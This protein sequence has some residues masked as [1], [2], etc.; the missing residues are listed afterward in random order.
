MKCILCAV[1]N[2]DE[3]VERLV[4]YKEAGFIVSLNLHPYSPGHLIIFP[5]RH[6]LDIREI[7]DEEGLK[8]HQ[9][10]QLSLDVLGEIYQPHGFNLGYNIG[11]PSGASLEH[12]HFHIVPR[13]G[14]EIGFLDV[15][16]GARVIVE[17]PVKTREKLKEAFG[18]GDA[19]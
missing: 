14:N 15:I 16:N 13:Y 3:R 18:N 17:D 8:L 9:L 12:L 6:V 11:R 2:N 1:A 7:S 5:E 10:S 4:V 19:V